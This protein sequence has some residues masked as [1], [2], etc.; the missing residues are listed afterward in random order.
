MTSDVA[1]SVVISTRNRARYL[2]EGLRSLACQECDSPFE[3]I[4]IDNA[5][6]DDTKPVLEAW[7]RRDSRFTTAFEPR[8]GT[9]CGKNTGI[10]LA[11]APLL[12]FTDDDT[13]VDAHWIQSYVD[14]FARRRED[15]LI[16]GGAIVPI[17]HDLGAWPTWLPEAA[18]ADLATLDHR[19]ERQ[20]KPTEYLWGANIAIPKRIFERFGLWDETIGRQGEKRGTSEDFSKEPWEYEDTEIQDRI[21]KAGGEV[22]FSPVSVVRH[23]VPRHAITPRQIASTAFTRGR[24]DFWA[25]HLPLWREVRL[26]PRRNALKVLP[27]LSW[28]LLNWGF[29]LVAFRLLQ[30]KQ[31]FERARLSA[32]ASGRRMDSLWAGRGLTRLSSSVNRIVFVIR[33][34]LLRLSPDTA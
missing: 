17:P 25:T 22:W 32:F 28:S 4:V 10:R 29:W 15:L 16:C 14:L 5:S 8:L 12:L 7:C 19:E 34:V 33:S 18:L 20:L 27:L 30:R 23:R 26:G 24:N 11:R 21:R 9:S 2:V 13:V 1:V 31:F 3:V 6:T